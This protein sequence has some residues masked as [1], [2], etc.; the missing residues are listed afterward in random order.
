M[1]VRPV[2]RH[3]RMKSM[4]LVDPGAHPFVGESDDFADAVENALGEV[5]LDLEADAVARRCRR[6]LQ[7]GAGAQK[8]VEHRV[9]LRGEHADQ[10]VGQLERECAAAAPRPV[11]FQ[12]LA[13]AF[14]IE[15]HVGIPDI[16]LLPEDGAL[17]AQLLFL[18]MGELP[19]GAFAQHQDELVLQRHV[20]A[21]RQHAGAHELVR[22]IGLLAPQD[23]RQRREPERE[24]AGENSRMV[25][26]EHEGIADGSGRIPD[27]DAGE[28]ARPEN[29]MRLRPHR[30]Q[31]AV[32]GFESGKPVLLRRA[33]RGR[34]GSGA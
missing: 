14:Q 16:A 11:L 10:P 8:G 25:R 17:A 5:G 24:A 31:H 30:V 6:G 23:G 19:L 9:A 4:W 34:P 28:A 33:R 3:C 27:V 20:G 21:G 18:R 22:R 26:V 15:P 7:G 13:G 2:S 29:A 12:T 32:H 1:R